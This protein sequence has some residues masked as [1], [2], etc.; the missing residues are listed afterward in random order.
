MLY[1]MLAHSTF[2]LLQHDTLRSSLDIFHACRED[3]SGARVWSLAVKRKEKKLAIASRHGRHEGGMPWDRPPRAMHTATRQHITWMSA[4]GFSR[5]R[6]SASSCCL[7]SSTMEAKVTGEE[8]GGLPTAPSTQGLR[9]GAGEEGGRKVMTDKQTD[10]G[11]ELRCSPEKR[12]CAD[13]GRVN[14]HREAPG[15]GRSRRPTESHDP[16]TWFQ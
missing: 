10:R 12:E 14:N 8:G 16:L 9:R 5:L 3:A 4:S 2:T 13:K 1:Y 15:R 6:I 11:G 7:S